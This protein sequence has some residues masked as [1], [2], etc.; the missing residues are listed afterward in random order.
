MRKVTCQ[1]CKSRYGDT[2]IWIV[3]GS[4]IICESCRLA[5]IDYFKDQF[6]LGHPFVQEFLTIQKDKRK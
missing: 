2:G 1:S 6:D 4:V 5:V 3:F